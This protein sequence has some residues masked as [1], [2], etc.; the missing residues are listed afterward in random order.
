MQDR[1]EHL[2]VKVAETL[3]DE[4]VAALVS[5]LVAGRDTIQLRASLLLH[6]YLRS[7]D[8]CR[9]RYRRQLGKGSVIET[10]I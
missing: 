3:R 5:L 4:V 8:N 2:W 9:F 6:K 1:H 7:Q 10:I